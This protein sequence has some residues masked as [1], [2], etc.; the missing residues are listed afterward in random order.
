MSSIKFEKY[1]QRIGVYEKK[2]DKEEI[3]EEKVESELGHDFLAENT[4]WQLNEAGDGILI[5]VRLH[6]E[7]ASREIEDVGFKHIET[8]SYE[9]AKK[10]VNISSAGQAGLFAIFKA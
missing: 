2:Y 1:G 5:Y 8:L 3:E 4:A 10:R 7:Y 9:E 6:H